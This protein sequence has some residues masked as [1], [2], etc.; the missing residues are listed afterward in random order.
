MPV[1]SL[2][3]FALL[4]GGA[5]VG[6]AAEATA[7]VKHR[8]RIDLAPFDC[9]DFARSSF[10]HRVC[11]DQAT[12]YMLIDLN[13]T[14]YDYCEVDRGT[15]DRLLAFDSIGKFFNNAL[16]GT[17]KDGPFDCRTHHVPN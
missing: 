3:P 4:L 8:G 16:K 6:K 11:Y 5:A 9:K 17:G 14:Y 1:K 10:I 7:D 13:G 2:L 12:S 15:V